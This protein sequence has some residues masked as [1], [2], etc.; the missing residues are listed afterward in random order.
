M[1][2][3][4]V[5]SFR[6]LGGGVLG[7]TDVASVPSV[8]EEVDPFPSSTPKGY[9]RR[10]GNRLS[11]RRNPSLTAHGTSD[12]HP[13]R[14]S[15]PSTFAVEEENNDTLQRR[16]ASG[17][18]NT[19]GTDD[20]PITSLEAAAWDPGALANNYQDVRE[21]LELSGH[22]LTSVLNNPRETFMDSLYEAA[23]ETTFETEPH[24]P[25]EM[26]GV[27]PSLREVTFQVWAERILHP[28]L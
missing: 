10:E 24:P 9:P 5:R 2:R 13:R 20:A 26:A 7:G 12:N 3:R 21:E 27:P 15:A 23:F 18:P 22:N 17:E 19:V 14:R 25:L 6:G 8:A 16:R 11:R 28:G 1:E 4:R